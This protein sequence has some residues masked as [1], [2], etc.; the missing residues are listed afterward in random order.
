MTVRIAEC[1]RKS[2][3]ILRQRYANL[4]PVSAGVPLASKFHWWKTPMFILKFLHRRQHKFFFFLKRNSSPWVPDQIPC[5]LFIIPEIM[6]P[7]QSALQKNFVA[8][9]P[10]ADSA[11]PTGAGLYA[12]FAFAG[13]VCCSITHGAMT[14]VDVVKTRIQLSP[15]IYNKGMIGGFRQ[16]IQAEGAGALLTGFGPTAAGYFL[17]GAFKFGGYEFWKKTFIDLVGVDKAVENRTSNCFIHF[18]CVKHSVPG[19][20]CFCP[21]LPQ[22]STL[23]PLL[24][25]NS[26]LMLLFAHLKPPVLDLYESFLHFSSFPL[27][28]H[29]SNLITQIGVTTRLCR[30]LAR[31]FHPNLEGGRC[32]QGF[33]LRLRSHL[34]QAS[35]LY[36]GQV[37][38]LRKGCVS[39]KFWW[40]ALP[41]SLKHLF[42]GDVRTGNG[43]GWI[44][45]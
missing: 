27:P 14:P 21:S 43:G 45:F 1:L 4:V 41:L 17:Q 3:C 28:L 5:L 34:V 10:A 12:R 19:I 35:S 37:R 22:L 2:L 8:A 15:E 7:S 9:S 26:L 24:S 18:A 11:V 44:I 25:L 13:A 39:C 31:R 20:H 33:L 42:Y 30:R 36:H 32:P 29:H 6:F 40:W 16:V 23:L 38:C